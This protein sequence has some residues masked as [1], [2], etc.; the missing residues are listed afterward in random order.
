MSF[1]RPYVQP[2][3][4]YA[5]SLFK[6]I[7]VDFVINHKDSY[8]I[9][10]DN[11][12]DFIWNASRGKILL[13][14]VSCADS[15][16][17]FR[18]V[19][20][21][22]LHACHFGVDACISCCD[23]AISQVVNAI[24][25]HVPFFN[26]DQSIQRC[27]RRIIS[28]MRRNGGVYREMAEMICNFIRAGRL[29]PDLDDIV[30]TISEYPCVE[31]PSKPQPMLNI[32]SR[33]KY[34][35]EIVKDQF[36]YETGIQFFSVFNYV[37]R[38]PIEV[39][40]DLIIHN[41]SLATGE[42]VSITVMKRHVQRMRKLDLIPFKLIN[43]LLKPIP[44]ITLEKRIYGSLIDRLTYSLSKEL[45][46]RRQLLQK[47]GI[48][49]T[50][51]PSQIFKAAR[52]IPLDFYI[53]APLPHLCSTNVLVTDS[54]PSKL[55]TATITVTKNSPSNSPS[56]QITQKYIK[57]KLLQSEARSV[58]NFT[59]DL[60]YKHSLI[61]P[62]LGISNLRKL[63][64]RL[65]LQKFGS[66]VHL[67]NDKFSAMLQIFHSYSSKN[68]KKAISAAQVLGLPQEKIVK[69]MG[70]PDLSFG[71]VRM[72]LKDNG[73]LLLPLAEAS[74]GMVNSIIDSDSS[75]FAMEPFLVGAY[76]KMNNKQK[77]HSSFPYN[78]L[79]WAQ[80]IPFKI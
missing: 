58:V 3:A 75:L 16:W 30:T 32:K 25:P 53:A 23:L 10:S 78:L 41:A 79:R 68:Q 72:I 4:S 61:V 64:D 52:Q 9:A 69:M 14:A 56:E 20:S 2:N 17:F 50:Q 67:D 36:E 27:T 34:T 73:S 8:K 38:Y 54:A 47:F 55:E 24:S 29:S 62:D 19:A 26:S 76:A 42:R 15:P 13:Y 43:L 57:A 66:M 1:I 49:F 71:S 22:Y 39:S 31:A 70:S 77:D 35:A 45:E 59:S 44:F 11:V 6:T 12:F 60:L 28:T 37:D 7:G 18:Q 33:N 40:N 51:S 80:Y 74:C 63:N 21:S 65:S 5:K 46:A 48:D